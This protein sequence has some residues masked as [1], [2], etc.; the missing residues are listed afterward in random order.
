MG[1]G[2]SSRRTDHLPRSGRPTVG[3]E[4]RQHTDEAVTDDCGAQV[5]DVHLLGDVRRRVVDDGAPTLLG[6]VDAQAPAGETCVTC[7]HNA[8]S[9]TTRFRKPGPDTVTSATGEDMSARSTSATSPANSTG[10]VRVRL[11][12]ASAALD[13]KSACS[14]GR[15]T[16]SAPL[17]SGQV[18]SRAPD[19]AAS[20]RLTSEH[21]VLFRLASSHSTTDCSRRPRHQIGGGRSAATSRRRRG[22]CG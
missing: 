10:L 21:L 14:E 20:T 19:T 13:W 3:A 5:P 1:D 22:P 8:V 6:R 18:R 7:F 2:N 17:S 12:R 15:T 11:A 9:A 16:G 4:E